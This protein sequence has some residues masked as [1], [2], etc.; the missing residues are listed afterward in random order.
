[1]T[2]GL[3]PRDEP[4]AP[5]R[6]IGNSSAIDLAAWLLNNN[7]AVRSTRP[8]QGG[9]LYTLEDCPF[10][11]AHKDIQRQLQM[12]RDATSIVVAGDGC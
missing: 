11:P 4:P 6:A 9:T 8:Y 1:M 10:S 12:K 3:L 5:K 7:I 2:A